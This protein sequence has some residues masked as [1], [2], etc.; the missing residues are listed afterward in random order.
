MP[1]SAR[2]GYVYVW[3]YVVPAA[4][5]AAFERVYGA[6]GAWVE[7]LGRAGGYRATQLLAEAEHEGR[8]MTI[9]EWDSREAFELFRAEHAEAFDA[10][11]ARCAEL[12]SQEEPLGHFRVV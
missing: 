8:Y 7:L 10:L 2:S 11:D 1:A 9:D 5:R 12:T 4:N 6:T 3:R